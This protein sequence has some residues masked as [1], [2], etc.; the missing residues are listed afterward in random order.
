MAYHTYH[1][2]QRGSEHGDQGRHA[3]AANEQ[4]PERL[5]E[6]GDAGVCDERERE[7]H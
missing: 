1:D 3:D 4:L 2:S 7:D 5:V 6:E